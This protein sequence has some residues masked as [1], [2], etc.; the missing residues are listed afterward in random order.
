MKTGK[1]PSA[2]LIRVFVIGLFLFGITL[3]NSAA[4]AAAEP[5]LRLFINHTENF[6][7]GSIGT[8]SIIVDNQLGTADATTMMTVTITLP[9]GLTYES[10]SGVGWSC[11][12]TTSN[13]QAPDTVV[14]NITEYVFAP[15]NSPREYT[16]LDLLVRVDTNEYPDGTFPNQ[17]TT[18]AIASIDG[19]SITGNNTDS[20]P[21]SIDKSDLFITGVTFDPAQPEA[22][23]PFDILV[24]V[25]NGG[26][27]GSESVVY[28]DV[29]VNQS[30]LSQ[31]PDGC[32]TI[33]PSSP[34][35]FSDWERGDFNDAIVQGGEVEQPVST[36]THGPSPTYGTSLPQGT[37]QIYVMAD[38]TCINRESNEN[39]NIYGPVSLTIKAPYVCGLV[40]RDVANGYWACTF[41]ETLSSNGVTG[42][43][44]VDANGKDYCPDNPVTRAQMAVFLEKG[45]HSSSY[46]PPNV[47][48]SFLDTA[49]HWAMIWI[50]ALKNDG[51]TSGCG[52][53]NY[54]PDFSTTRAQMAV[55][56]LKAKHGSAYVPPAVGGSTGFND[57]PVG[58]WAAAW[59]KQLAAENITGGC[60]NNN[61]CPESPVTRAQMAVFLVRTFDLK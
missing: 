56:L 2:S 28:R 42:G 60:G 22:D 19:E 55:F 45:I 39:N 30:P 11:P 49:G 31:D 14:C 23:Q 48:A 57:V 32:T 52:N 18:N 7:I 61:Y 43:C 24:T 10:H 13:P 21:T 3:M 27:A 25:K 40:F 41:I 46:S 26:L 44:L 12:T 5:N 35:D 29:F 17:L 59:I 20:D 36:L 51:V 16:T 33:S 53:G 38:A 15:P 34:A 47:P 54:C 1:I 8:Y 4:R 6:D 9:R 50:E 37:Y 58:Y